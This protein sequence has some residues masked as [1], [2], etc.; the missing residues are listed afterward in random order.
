MC[1]HYRIQTSS[2]V[3][4]RDWQTEHVESFENVNAYK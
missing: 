4:K 2:E 1:R 3:Y